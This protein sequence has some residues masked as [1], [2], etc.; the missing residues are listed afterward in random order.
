M[1]DGSCRSRNRKDELDSVGEDRNQCRTFVKL[2]FYNPY[3]YFT[4]KHTVTFIGYIITDDQT[5]REKK[6]I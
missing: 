1:E 4:Y 5:V 2:G 3:S 6:A